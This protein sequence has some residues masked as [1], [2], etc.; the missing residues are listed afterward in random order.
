[1][2]TNCEQRLD[3]PCTKDN[4]TSKIE[5]ICSLFFILFFQLLLLGV[6]SKRLCTCHPPNEGNV[7]NSLKGT[8]TQLLDPTPACPVCPLLGARQHNRQ[9]NSPFL[10][11]LHPI[12]CLSSHRSETFTASPWISPSR[13]T[14]SS[15]DGIMTIAPGNLMAG[16]G[17]DG[18]TRGLDD[19]IT[20]HGLFWRRVVGGSAAVFD[21]WCAVNC[22]SVM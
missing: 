2:V 6:T 12:G 15:V 18:K 8:N 5:L 7:T 11:P 9:R 13:R 14:P 20:F 21:F 16:H 1:M 17:C 4:I 3:P 22:G 10:H 19:T